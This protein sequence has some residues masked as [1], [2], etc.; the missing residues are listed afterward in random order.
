MR[1]GCVFLIS[2]RKN[3]IKECLTQFD[4]N[5]NRRYNYPILIF[6]HGNTYDDTSLRKSISDINPSTEVR[7]HQIEA[8]IPEHLE[9]KDM[10]WNYPNNYA[11][12]FGKRRIGYLHANYFWNNFMNYEEL[13]E[14]D[15]LHRI[16]DDSWFKQEIPFNFFEEIDNRSGYF[17]TAL[18]WNHFH[19]NHLETR[20]NL[21]EWIKSYVNKYDIHVK[22]DTLR[23]SL[24]GPTDNEKF[25]TLRWNCGN[26]NIYNRKMFNTPEWKRY[27]TEF[28][29]HGGGY[30]YRWVDI[31]VIGLFA[32]IHLDNPLVDFKLKEQGIYQGK[33]PHAQMV[34]S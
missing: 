8:K 29:Q 22:N 14:F 31:E 17:G 26:C 34:F 27:L 16:D 10:F 7:F 21:F 12:S 3:L 25:H 1:N 33:V 6:Y 19:L 2:A 23:E 4:K 11:R 15:Y 30:R 5:Y 13:S 20:V 18:T 9:E 24:L 32:Y 28:N